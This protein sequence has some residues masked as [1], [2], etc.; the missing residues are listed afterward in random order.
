MT[1]HCIF[2]EN[3]PTVRI[4]SSTP[5]EAKVTKFCMADFLIKVN[6]L[7]E[8]GQNSSFFFSIQPNVAMYVD[9]YVLL[10][11]RYGGPNLAF[12]EIYNRRVLIVTE[13]RISAVNSIF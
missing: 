7:R 3:D 8:F 11:G 12:L 6:H 9:I 2:F 13:R 10:C 4:H 5:N 1:K